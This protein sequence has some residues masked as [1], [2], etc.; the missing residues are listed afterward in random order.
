MSSLAKLKILGLTG[1]DFSSF[2]EEIFLLVSLEKLYIG[3]DQGSKFTYLPENIKKLQVSPLNEQTRSACRLPLPP[4]LR[5]LEAM[6]P[7]L[8]KTCICF[9]FP[10]PNYEF[11][12]FEA[13]AVTE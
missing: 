5:E 9:R 13:L 3:Q 11:H 10:V 6:F 2:P 12:N 7:A 4:M 1:N 8:Q